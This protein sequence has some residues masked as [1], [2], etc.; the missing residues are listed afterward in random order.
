[1]T[2]SF[3]FTLMLYFSVIIAMLF[4]IILL[5]FRRR[6]QI[7]TGLVFDLAPIDEILE[8]IA[9]ATAHY[10]DVS[11]VLETVHQLEELGEDAIERLMTYPEQVRAA[12]I[13]Y[14]AD[15]LG[16]AINALS[17]AATNE[18]TQHSPGYEQRAAAL[19]TQV[20]RLQKALDA[21]VTLSGG[22][23]LHAV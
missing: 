10:A 15:Q 7:N 18:R 23:S 6:P 3:E 2:D 21:L 11:A 12:S 19:D 5:L 17:V 22:K 8:Q 1:M 16:R 20:E 9:A 14:R 13:M 4:V